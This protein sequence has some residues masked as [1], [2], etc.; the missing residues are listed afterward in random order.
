MESKVCTKCKTEKNLLNF[1]K[2]KNTKSGF[3]SRCKDCVKLCSKESQIN[4]KEYRKEYLKNYSKENIIYLRENK[5]TYRENNREYFTNYHRNY[6]VERRK[7]D[8][9]FRVKHNVRNRLW[10]AFKNG[11][12]KKEGSEKLL[13]AK[14]DFVITYIESLFTKGMSWDNYG[15]WHID[16]IIPLVNAKTKEEAEKLCNYKNLQPLWAFDNLS[17]GI[18]QQKSI[19]PIIF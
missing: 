9:L 7:K 6:H 15:E 4:N 8:I 18:K 14:Y 2:D 17:K 3:G 13:G 12:W 11:N 10:S 16:H 5:K 19:N 1:Y